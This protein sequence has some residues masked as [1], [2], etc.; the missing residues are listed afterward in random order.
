VAELNFAAF[1]EAAAVERNDRIATLGPGDVLNGG[2]IPPADRSAEAAAA[3]GVVMA[4][5]PPL[6]VAGLSAAA[7]ETKVSLWD[8]WKPGFGREWPGVHQIT[9]SCV[10]A[11][12]GNALFSLACADVVRRRDPERVEVPFWLL[13]YGIS[14]ML[15]GLNSRGDGSFGSTFARAVREFGHLPAGGE[16]LPPYSEPDG[17]VW[18]QKAELDWS[19]G[20]KIPDR[21]LEAARPYLVRSTAVCRTADDVRDA[22]KNYYAVT[23]ASNWGGQMRPGVSGSG[24]DARLVN[25]RATTWNHQMSVQGWED[26]PTHGELFFIL[27]QWGRDAHG[28]CPSGAPA[29]GFWV[30][31]KDMQDIVSQGETFA[32]SQF[33]GFPALDRPLDFS[34]F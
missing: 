9:G 2:W 30:K 21:Y 6:F 7:D 23:C 27:N 20:S 4:T 14:R 29:G 13:P 33:D 22:V 24:A 10:G 25:R 19:Q 32:F 31:K 3:H 34:A 18:G 16:G 11:G 12:G 15:G 17:L 5:T 26:N 1:D 28:R 8:C